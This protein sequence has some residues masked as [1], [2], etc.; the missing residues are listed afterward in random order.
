MPSAEEPLERPLERT[1]DPRCLRVGKIQVRDERRV[2]FGEAT[3]ELSALEQ[4][5]DP[6]H[7][8]TL[9]RAMA[10]LGEECQQ[11]LPLQHALDRIEAL[12]AEQGLEV[13]SPRNYP[14]G[15]LLFPRRHELAAALNRFRGLEIWAEEG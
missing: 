12:L 7:A 10:V 4:I 1:L 13:L 6:Q 9:A 11:P 14:D 8:W 3:L 15:E 2:R 5:L